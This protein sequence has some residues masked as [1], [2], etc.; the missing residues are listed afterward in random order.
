MSKE[1]II[2]KLNGKKEKER[3]IREQAKHCLNDLVTL[4]NPQ[5]DLA[6]Q[7]FEDA[8]TL[9]LNPTEKMFISNL[10]V[11]KE[12]FA[13]VLGSGDFVID[14]SYHGTR[15]ILTFDING[16][17]YYPA[18]LKLKGLQNMSYK[19]Y[20][21]FFS[22]VNSPDYLSQEKYKELKRKAEQ[23]LKLYAFMDEIISQR[24]KDQ[25]NLKKYL[26]SL[27]IDIN[28][29]KQI[30]SLM[31]IK[32]ENMGDVALDKAISMITPMY[33]PSVTFRTISGLQGNKTKQSYLENEVSYQKAQKSIKQTNISFLKANLT[34]LKETL[35]SSDYTK[36][37][38]YNRFHSIYLS[39]IPEYLNGETFANVV[40]QELIPLLQEDGVIA[41]CCQSTNAKTL[42]MDDRGLN[43]LKSNAKILISQ[44]SSPL[45]IYQMINS[46]EGFRKI[47]KNHNVD[48]IETKTLSQFNGLE[49]NDT[50]VYIR[51]RK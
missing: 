27:E 14:A 10:I 11:S 37:E 48:Y 34:K 22:N 25:I 46:I 49:E 17:Q 38:E 45:S 36:R 28:M 24:R 42:K 47:S 51:K 35:E 2:T 29:L 3:I 1:T 50:Y 19:E 7:L 13:T 18:A 23:D 43:E 9:Y 26:N 41:Y 32:T 5:K 16:N 12:A 8:P 39:N 15:E 33:E 21:N 4:E 30:G 40:E 6:N 44:E 31:G 20:W